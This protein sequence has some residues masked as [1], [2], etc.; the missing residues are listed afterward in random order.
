[1]TVL[2]V[3]MTQM[4]LQ[5]VDLTQPMEGNDCLPLSGNSD[6]T[7]DW[8]Q[9]AGGDLGDLPVLDPHVWEFLSGRG[10]SGSGGG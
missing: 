2:S 7:V 4:R 6:E 3:P 8:S 9:P 1:M 5:T 10:S